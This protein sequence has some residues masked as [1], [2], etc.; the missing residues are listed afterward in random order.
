MGEHAPTTRPTTTPVLGHEQSDVG[1][2]PL[3]IFLAGLAALIVFVALVVAWLFQGF[4]HST[5]GRETG[6]PGR[7][8]SERPGVTEP[9]LQ[10]SSRADMDALRRRETEWLRGTAW[11][12][13]PGGVVRMP[14]ERAMELAVERGFPEW[15]KVDVTPPAAAAPEGGT[16]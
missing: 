16:P 2:R 8:A 13:E 1:F 14:I 5:S 4:E 10:I 6:P 9:L 11:V 12:D 15:P 7:S 3:A